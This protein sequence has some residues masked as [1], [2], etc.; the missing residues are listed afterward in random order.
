MGRLAPAEILILRAI[1]EFGRH[2]VVIAGEQASSY[3]YQRDF[4][5]AH[6]TLTN[7]AAR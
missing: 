2:H 3:P 7:A 6:A 1:I 4:A 5:R